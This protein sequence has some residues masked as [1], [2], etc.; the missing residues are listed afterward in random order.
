MPKK[1][2]A[3]AKEK[4]Q[5]ERFKE[6]ARKVGAASNAKKFQRVFEKAVPAKKGKRASAS[7]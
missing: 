6:L 1:K 5:H 2:P 4:P 3:D 7:A